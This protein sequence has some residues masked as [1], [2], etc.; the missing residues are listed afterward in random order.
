MEH[1]VEVSSRL[2]GL[3]QSTRWRTGTHICW[4]H[5]INLIALLLKNPGNWIHFNIGC[6]LWFMLGGRSRKCSLL[7]EKKCVWLAMEKFCRAVTV[8]GR[9]RKE[10]KEVQIKLCLVGQIQ[11]KKASYVISL[12]VWAFLISFFFLAKL[13]SQKAQ[14]IGIY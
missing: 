2:Q 4:P 1:E 3:S 10:D 13:I 12:V 14:F 5:S 6:N 8:L 7:K 11:V 9:V